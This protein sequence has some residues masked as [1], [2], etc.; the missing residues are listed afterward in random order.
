[1]LID[2][3]AV[4]VSGRAADPLILAGAG[5]ESPC[6]LDRLARL[7]RSRRVLSVDDIAIAVFKVAITFGFDGLLFPV[8]EA[9]VDALSCN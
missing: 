8:G 5:R 3:V 6:I 1:M 2:V 4:A 7:W 9:D